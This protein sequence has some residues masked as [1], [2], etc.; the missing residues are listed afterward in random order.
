MP[1]MHFKDME[2]AAEAAAE[3]AKKAIAAAQAAAYLANKGPNQF[4]QSPGFRYNSNISSTDHG[5]GSYPVNSNGPFMSNNHPQINSQNNMSYAAKLP[6]RMQESESF[7]RSHFMNNEDRKPESG[8]GYRRHSYNAPRAHSDIKFDESDSDEEIDQNQDTYNGNDNCPR[9]GRD[10]PPVPSS[11]FQ[12]SPA[13]GVHPKLP[14]YDTLAARFEA[15][16]YRKV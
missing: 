15:L 4:T 13:P 2:S 10:P 5:L 12:Q 3:S 14:D 9:P 6:G 11:N 8:G 16:K 7:D 1:H